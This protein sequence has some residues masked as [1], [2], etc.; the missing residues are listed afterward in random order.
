MQIVACHD[1]ETSRQNA[2]W[3]RNRQRSVSYLRNQQRMA[4]Q[5]R[6]VVGE[7]E[8][9]SYSNVRQLSS[10]SR[11]IANTFFTPHSKQTAID[12]TRPVRFEKGLPWSNLP[13]DTERP[14][15]CVQEPS[16]TPTGQFMTKTF[17]ARVIVQKLT[18]IV[19]WLQMSPLAPNL[20]PS[21]KSSHRGNVFERAASV[22]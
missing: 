22:A 19:R 2:L 3:L 14:E 6:I 18:T 21:R 9:T 1:C 4:S 12:V 17:V 13:I 11:S 8:P 10:R 7:W 5:Y 20:T 15:C 16:P